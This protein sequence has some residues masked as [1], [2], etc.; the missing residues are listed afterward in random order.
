MRILK[1]LAVFQ[2]RVYTTFNGIL[3]LSFSKKF[4]GYF[5]EIII[6]S[7]FQSVVWC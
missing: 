1:E 4:F 7:V 2:K 3:F 6:P 5:W